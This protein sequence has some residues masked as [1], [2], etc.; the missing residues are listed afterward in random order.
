MGAVLQRELNDAAV[1]YPES[2]GRARGGSG[3]GGNAKEGGSG[4]LGGNW[5]GW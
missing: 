2:G 3:A 5:F 4:V 1:Y